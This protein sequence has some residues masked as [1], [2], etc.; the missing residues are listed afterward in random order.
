MDSHT[1]TP[2]FLFFFFFI[3]SITLFFMTA[4]IIYKE[5]DVLLII[6][7]VILCLGL[8]YLHPGWLLFFLSQLLFFKPRYKKRRIR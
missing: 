5:A 6:V 4:K 8:N 7:T 1:L 2:R 3:F